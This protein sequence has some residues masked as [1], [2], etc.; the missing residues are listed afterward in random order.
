MSELNFNLQE[1]ANIAAEILGATPEDLNNALSENEINNADELKSILKPYA[2]KRFNGLREEALNKGF[3]QASKKVERLWGEVFNED[4][5]G[6]K[7]EDLF[8]NYRDKLRSKKP[9]EDQKQ[10]ITLQKALQSDE[11][12]Q[13]INGLKQQAAEAEQIR[14]DFKSF[15]N[16]QTI[17][18]QALNVLNENGANFSQNPQIKARQ[19]A[20]LESEL[21]RLNF[22]NENGEFTILDDDG[23]PLFNKETANYWNFNDYIK[24]LSPVDFL[25][26]QTKENKKTF[27]PMDKGQNGNNYGFNESQLNGLNYDDF[28]AALNSGDTEK[29]NFIQNQMIKNYE[30]NK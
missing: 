16:L 3:R 21:K 14:N 22:K 18:A 25:S 10:N 28:K 11:I 29:A 26:A 12:K 23:Q 19:M 2:V 1:V 9:G 8:I 5:S 7:L 4:I 6:Q 17:K 15:K 24:T 13:Y 27:V 20:A 30:N